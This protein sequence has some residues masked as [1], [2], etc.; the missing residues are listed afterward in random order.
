MQ[1]GRVLEPRGSRPIG[2][3]DQA[4]NANVSTTDTLMSSY[5]DNLRKLSI[6]FWTPKCQG[7]LSEDGR[8]TSGKCRTAPIV[9]FLEDFGIH[10][11]LRLRKL[12][13]LTLRGRTT[14][15]LLEKDGPALD[16]NAEQLYA[17]AQL[18]YKLK[19]GFRSR[20]QVVTIHILFM[21]KD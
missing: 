21:Y 11:L 15:S 20:G 6:T 5:F 14:S 4:V 3:V 7:K 16:D 12:Q 1:R 2:F 19:D 17:I 18:G 9:Q 10:A 8:V 13:K